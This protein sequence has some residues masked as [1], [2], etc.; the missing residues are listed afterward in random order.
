MLRRIVLQPGQ[1]LTEADLARSGGVDAEI[2]G[3]AARIV[4]DVRARGDVALRELTAQL[5]KCELEQIVVTEAEIAAVELC[6]SFHALTVR[7]EH[8]DFHRRQLR[9]RFTTREDGCFR[10]KVLRSR[11]GIY[12]LA[13]RP[14]PSAC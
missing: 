10:Q 3:V 11:V 2:L 4:E 7:Q 1:R 14:L 9:S 5:D 13:A 8:R 12:V 6:R